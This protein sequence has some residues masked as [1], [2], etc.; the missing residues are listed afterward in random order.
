MTASTLGLLAGVA[1][2][3][4]LDVAQPSLRLTIR[5]ASDAANAAWR[6]GASPTQ[7]KRRKPIRPTTARRALSGRQAGSPSASSKS[8]AA[9]VQSHVARADPAASELARPLLMIF[10]GPHGYVSASWYANDTIP[11]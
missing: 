5:F 1:S 11:T 7:L 2:K 4:P 3:S 6:G 8:D 9:V 10:H